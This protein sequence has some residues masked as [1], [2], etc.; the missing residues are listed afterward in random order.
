MRAASV[1]DDRQSDLPLTQAHRA[2]RPAWSRRHL[3]WT[4][5]QRARAR[6]TDEFPFTLFFNDGRVRVWRRQ[7]ERFHKARVGEHD[8]L[9]RRVT[10]R[11]GGLRTENH[12]TPLHRVQ[13]NL[14]GIVYRVQF[15]SRWY[16]CAQKSPYGHMRFTP[17]LRSFPNVAFETVLMFV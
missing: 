14:A 7:G 13:G 6:F 3:P 11:V 4:R 5:Q 9:W 1:Q 15:S 10:H 8:R 17:S 16:L 12:R 2:A